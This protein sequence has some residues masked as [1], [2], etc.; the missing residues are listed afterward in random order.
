MILMT[1]DHFHTESLERFTAELVAAG[2]T[3]VAGYPLP[4]WRGTIH[5]G[6]AGLTD[7][8]HMDIVIVPGW[9]F[10]PPALFVQG[11]SVSHSTPEG[12]VCLWQEGDDSFE[13]E[14]LPGFH[15]RVAEWCRQ[16]KQGWQGDDLQADAYLN[17]RLK[18]P[19]VATFDLTA[20]HIFPGSWGECHG[21][22]D[23]ET[24]RVDIKPGLRRQESHL[25]VL[26]FHAGTLNN[27][28]PPRLLSEVPRHLS[29]QQR[30]GLQ[31]ALAARLRDD[32]LS[33]SA[34][35]DIILFC[36][37]RNHQPNLLVL[38][39]Q[40]VGDEIKGYAMMPGPNDEQNLILRAGPDAALLIGRKA[41]LFGAGALGGYVAMT[42]AQSGLGSIN[43]VDSDLLMPG[44][45]ARHAAG[46]QQ[47]GKTKVAAVECAIKEHAPWTEVGI[48]VE[49][50]LT[51]RSIH[52]H[53]VDVDVAI[54]ATGN[55]AFTAA[56]AMVAGDA[57]K[58]MVSGALYRGGFVSRVR[59]Q[60]LTSDAPINHREE[61]PEYPVIP[62][63]NASAEF[64]T[65]E[66]GCSAPVNNAPPAS[67]T[68]CAA[69][70]A[71][72]AIDALTRRFEYGDEVIDIHRPLPEP[73]F[74]RI[75]RVA[76]DA[77]RRQVSTT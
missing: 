63:G 27:G 6:F 22:I 51:P 68:A 45:V 19:R 29:R 8:E 65:S 50:P 16:A 62:Q 9:P 49:A 48:Y 71:Q 32:L 55:A 64:A 38:A 66:T 25:K 21:A 54:D 52:P 74:N 70:I 75:G 77:S 18:V 7:S 47:V 14:T 12:F 61:S 28:P 72:I 31:R 58:P 34:G 23:R 33:P 57:Q 2:F 36:W 20:L 42:L 35:C 56:L 3:P 30:K 59:R 67:V 41:T 76:R 5:P 60:A 46:H 43:L 73:P 39:C 10:R 53:I 24:R 37:E 11:L 13:W 15:D 40:G 44:N 1:G 69:L 26:W 17:F 4:A